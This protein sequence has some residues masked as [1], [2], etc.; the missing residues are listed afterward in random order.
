MSF[1]NDIYRELETE[2]EGSSRID[3]LSAFYTLLNYIELIDNGSGLT[4]QDLQER[5]YQRTEYTHIVQK[6]IKHSVLEKSSNG[7]YILNKEAKTIISPMFEDLM[8]MVYKPEKKI[9][10][11]DPGLN[12]LYNCR[13]QIFSS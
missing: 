11:K 9:N 13:S 3:H 12:L 5:F 8:S 4:E 6:L 7:N 10:S 2:Y 1:L